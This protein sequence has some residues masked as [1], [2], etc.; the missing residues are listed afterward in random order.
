VR[1]DLNDDAKLNVVAR[2][3]ELAGAPVLRFLSGL[4]REPQLSPTLRQAALASSARIAAAL[5]PQRSAAGGT[6]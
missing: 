4:A 2:L 1:A 6:P 3:E 5:A